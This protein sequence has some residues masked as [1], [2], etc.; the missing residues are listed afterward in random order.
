L[1]TCDAAANALLVDDDEEGAYEE[2]L[3]AEEE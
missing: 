1:R 2:E 3:P